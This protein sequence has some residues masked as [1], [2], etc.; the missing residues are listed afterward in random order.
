MWKAK[1]SQISA[2]TTQ[3]RLLKNG[4]VMSYQDWI[5]Q[6]Q[7]DDSFID[8]F[9]E[10]LKNSP[11]EGF[12]WEVKPV[13]EDQLNEDFEF[14][15]VNS[16]SLSR[17]QPQAAAFRAYFQ[18]EEEIVSFPNLSGDAQLVVPCP[19]S[20]VSCYTH[21]ARFIRKA[22]P[23]QIQSFWK[24]V[25]EAYFQSIGNQKKWLST[26]GLGVYWLHVRIDSRPKYYHYQP[27]K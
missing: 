4:Q 21:L 2:G 19:I 5:D 9:S 16:A 23:T 24:V 18:Q 6:I 25:G 1:T 15:L 22:P 12:F 27:Y 20:D 8:F 7:S 17:V 3:F 11:F 26:H 14:V 13:K 10:I